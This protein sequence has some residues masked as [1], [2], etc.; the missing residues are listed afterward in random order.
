MSALHID[1]IYSWNKKTK[2][3]L[4]LDSDTRGMKVQV[5]LA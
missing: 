4:T 1:Q 2:D 5:G 3:P